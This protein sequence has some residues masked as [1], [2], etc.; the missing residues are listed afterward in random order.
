MPTLSKQHKFTLI[1]LLVVIA[2]TAT[3]AA[4]LL[5]ALR[6]ARDLAERAVCLSNK[7]QLGMTANLFAS[8]YDG[9]VPRGVDNYTGGNRELAV[10]A[11]LNRN[12]DMLLCMA[13]GNPAATRLDPPGVMAA[14]GYIRNADILYCPRLGTRA[15]HDYAIELSRPVARLQRL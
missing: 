13:V 4:M 3:L 11:S 14:F 1:E 9:R 6:H 15:E 5:P 10:Y 12:V 7:R 8:D 2:I